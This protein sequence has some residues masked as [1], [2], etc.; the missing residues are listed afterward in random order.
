MKR[1][2]CKWDKRLGC[3]TSRK[4]RQ[5]GYKR[6]VNSKATKRKEKK[7]ENEGYKGERRTLRWYSRKE[8]NR[9]MKKNIP[10]GRSEGN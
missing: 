9:N 4:A 1:I 2:T 7:K 8:K 5:Q 6:I 3:V 10:A